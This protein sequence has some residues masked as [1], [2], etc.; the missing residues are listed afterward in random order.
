VAKHTK[1]NFNI[2][3]GKLSPIKFGDRNYRNNEMIIC[4]CDCGQTCCIKSYNLKI[5]KTKSCGCLPSGSTKE[6]ITNQRFERLIVLDYLKQNSSR[7]SIWLCQCD[8]G[9]LTQSSRRNLISGS[10]KSCGCYNKDY[11]KSL[12]GNS[13]PNWNPNLSDKDR[14]NGRNIDE[15]K[16]WSFQVKKNFNFKCALCGDI[17]N[18][19]SHH[20][21]SYSS[22]PLQ[23][24][25][26]FN[27]VCLCSSCH[28]EFHKQYG[29]KNNTKEQYL[30][31]ANVR[32]ESSNS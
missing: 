8:C 18:I 21:N 28:I 17:N 24:T 31:Y 27:G 14:I 1:F 4:Q 16:D 13:N 29:F 30:E 9:S 19:V 15:Y 12:V 10:S 11:H 23:R 3:Y 26:V 32:L 25:D 20:M 7:D 5:G 22:F 2:K 6:D